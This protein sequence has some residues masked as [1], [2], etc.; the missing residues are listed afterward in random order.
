MVCY[1]FKKIK[2]SFVY[3]VIV[4]FITLGFCQL[5]EAQCREKQRD[6]TEV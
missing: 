6:Y 5:M 1:S 2:L 4:V 3:K